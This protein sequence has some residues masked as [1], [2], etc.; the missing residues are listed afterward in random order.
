MDS[1]ASDARRRL[2]EARA[3]GT[4]CVGW[5][6]PAGWIIQRL[7]HHLRQKAARTVNNVLTVLSMMLKR[8]VEW[9]AIDRMP[10]TVRLLKVSEGAVDLHACR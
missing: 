5:A 2:D 9:G 1:R 8:A 7:N 10:C 3:G 4:R 6:P